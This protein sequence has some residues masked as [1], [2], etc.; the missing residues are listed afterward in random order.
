MASVYTGVETLGK[1]IGGQPSAPTFVETIDV[2]WDDK[3]DPDAP[4]LIDDI[5]VG[6]FLSSSMARLSDA[7]KG[8]IAIA[9]DRLTYVS[10][11]ANFTV[12]AKITGATSGATAT[13]VFDE[14]AG[15]T[16]RLTLKDKS[17]DKDFVTGEVITDD[18]TVPGTATTAVVKP[19]VRVYQMNVTV[20]DE[21]AKDVDLTGVSVRLAITQY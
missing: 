9:D 17:P 14:D 6:T 5:I 21:C 15:T 20:L 4:L 7:T 10:Q 8:Y 1:R 3:Y 2:K 19:C 16:G 18:E 11:S 13:I 12:G